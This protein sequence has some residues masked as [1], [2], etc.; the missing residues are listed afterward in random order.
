MYGDFCTTLFTEIIPK[1]LA[2][3]HLYLG[4]NNTANWMRGDQ[5]LGKYCLFILENTRPRLLVS[6][7]TS[8][9]CGAHVCRLN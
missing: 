7:R 5:T 1:V 3:C 8:G 6:S 2:I 4:S 9:G